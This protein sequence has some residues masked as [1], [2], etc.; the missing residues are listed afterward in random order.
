MFLEDK[1]LGFVLICH[2]EQGEASTGYFDVKALG[3]MYSHSLGTHSFTETSAVLGKKIRTW[4]L[5]LWS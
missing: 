2:F 5:G 1:A 4:D 3:M